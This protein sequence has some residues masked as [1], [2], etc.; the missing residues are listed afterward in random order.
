MPMPSPPPYYDDG[1]VQIHH[2]DCLNVMIDLPAVD[3]TITDP[4]YNADFNYGSET[5]DRQDWSKYVTWLGDRI[6]LMEEVTAGP[7]IVFVSVRGMMEMTRWRR[8]HWT[9]GWFRPGSGH[10]TGDTRRGTGFQ[11]NW[12]PFLVYGDLSSIRAT[13]PDAITTNTLSERN[14][15]PCPKSPALLRRLIER[16]PHGT[17]ILD[18]FAGSG[19]TLRVAKDLGMRS[20]GIEINEGF[21]RIAANRCAQ[22]SLFHEEVQWE[23]F[24]S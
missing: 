2:G 17:S 10:P 23:L 22:E 14:G 5:D 18:P 3:V 4:P 13:L 15:H 12:E 7:V 11:S 6:E 20:V 9:G 19:T 8:P 24:T 1:L 16:F 21:C